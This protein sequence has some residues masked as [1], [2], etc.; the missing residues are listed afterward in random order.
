MPTHNGF[1]PDDGDG[2]NDA[3]ATPI[4]PDE[5]SPVDP[6]QTRLATRHTLPQNVQLM[7][8]DQDFGFQPPL[9]LKPVAQSTKQQE[10]DCE[11]LAIM[12][13]F[14]TIRESIGWNFRKRQGGIISAD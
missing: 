1:G 12:F 8:Q 3:R 14:A 6:A 11:H 7:T 9:R 4:E 5:E 10:A 13:R 2:V